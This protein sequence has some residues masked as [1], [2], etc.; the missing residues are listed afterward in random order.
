MT[1]QEPRQLKLTKR[2]M[3]YVQGRLAGKSKFQA[4]LLAGYSLHSACNAA[5]NIERRGRGGDPDIRK[6][7]DFMEAQQAQE[8]NGRENEKQRPA[9]VQPDQ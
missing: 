1:N 3:R 8:R 5:Y 7:V 9:Q 6:I 4:A 2:Q